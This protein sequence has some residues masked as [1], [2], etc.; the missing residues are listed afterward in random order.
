MRVAA[1]TAHAPPQTFYHLRWC[2]PLSHVRRTLPPPH[3]RHLGSL[4]YGCVG[5]GGPALLLLD[6]SL[7]PHRPWSTRRVQQWGTFHVMPGAQM[8]CPT[9]CLP[10]SASACCPC[11]GLG[12]AVPHPQPHTVGLAAW[13]AD[14][15]TDADRTSYPFARNGYDK[16]PQP[17]A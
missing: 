2:R 16:W 4:S 13:T 15:T 3:A 6:H 14:L 8:A 12:R 1:L 11:V 9:S 17:H 7:R 5:M 10:K